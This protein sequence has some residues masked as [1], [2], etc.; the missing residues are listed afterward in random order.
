MGSEAMVKEGASRGMSSGAPRA[1]TC[2]GAVL[3]DLHEKS[4]K[5]SLDWRWNT[6]QRYLTV[7]LFRDSIG[8]GG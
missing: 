8:M 3:L 1:R 2:S 5:Y 6:A 7:T 4:I